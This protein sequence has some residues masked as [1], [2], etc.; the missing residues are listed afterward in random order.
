[1]LEETAAARPGVLSSSVPGGLFT[2]RRP[3]RTATAD[4]TDDLAGAPLSKGAPG[5]NLGKPPTYPLWK[6]WK[7]RTDVLFER[8]KR[9]NQA[10]GRKQT[11][12]ENFFPCGFSGSQA[13]RRKQ[14]SC[15]QYRKGSDK[16]KEIHAYKKV[17]PGHHMVVLSDMELLEVRKASRNFHAH[18]PEN[19]TNRAILSCSVSSEEAGVFRVLAA[20]SGRTL[21]AWLRSAAVYWAYRENL[22]N[23][24][25]I[26]EEK[27]EKLAG[28]LLEFVIN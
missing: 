27:I 19:N 18:L 10:E 5:S 12:G 16:M 9:N 2:R 26:G 6:L 22:T 25:P 20:R 13:R 23:A 4:D 24:L 1:M 8:K 11:S 3:R 17:N 15:D 14:F 7:N 21:S 28:E